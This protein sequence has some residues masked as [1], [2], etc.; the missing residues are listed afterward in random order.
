MG[1]NIIRN[2]LPRFLVYSVVALSF[3]GCATTKPKTVD[4]KPADESTATVEQASQGPFTAAQNWASEFTADKA[5]R[6]V[7]KTV[8]D[9]KAARVARVWATQGEYRAIIV[10]KSTARETPAV[11]LHITQSDANGWSVT[12][13]E[14]A[15]STHLWSEL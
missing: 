7:R 9:W 11:L 2:P 5:P 3:V 10:Q 15:T 8:N 14:P 4:K 6:A 1:R 13:A 12:G